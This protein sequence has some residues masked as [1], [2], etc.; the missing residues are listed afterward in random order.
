MVFIISDIPN[1]SY[2]D[3]N[4]SAIQSFLS[5]ALFIPL[6]WVL[7]V[8]AYVSSWICRA[9]PMPKF[10]TAPSAPYAGEQ[11]TVAQVLR[12]GTDEIGDA[13]LCRLR[14]VTITLL[15]CGRRRSCAVAGVCV[16]S[17]VCRRWRCR[18]GRVGCLRVLLSTGEAY[19]RVGDLLARGWCAA[20]GVVDRGWE[21][22]GGE[23]GVLV[24]GWTSRWEIRIA[25][26][27][28]VDILVGEGI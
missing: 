28:R 10:E 15:S 12:S 1:F 9:S 26:V 7:S 3:T 27:L 6:G 16:K 8:W 17:P 21:N 4:S 24:L 23:D 18:W 11:D 25:R 13:F 2:R 22:E 14:V 19:R 20:V 5:P